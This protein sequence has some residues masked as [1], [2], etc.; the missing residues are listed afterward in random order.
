[1]PSVRVNRE[2]FLGVL[3]SVEPGLAKKETLEQ[4]NSFIFRK[5]R[6]LT[7]NDEIACRAPSGLS[8]EFTGAVAAKP[9]LALLDKLK[10]ETIHVEPDGGELIITG[11][12]GRSSGIL[13]DA[14]I[15]LDVDA[16]EEPGEWRQLPEGF[17]E[18]VSLVATCA[19]GDASY[20][21]RVCI[22]L[23]PKWIE[24]CDNYQITRYRI[25]TG[26]TENYLLRQ[27]SLSQ[28][29]A[30]GVTE[31]SESAAWAHF[32]FPASGLT[33]SCRRYL[34]EFP[35][36]SKLLE[37]GNAQ[38]TVLPKALAEAAERAEIFSAENADDNKLHIEMSPGKL[39][40]KGEGTKGWYRE[41]QQ[42]TYQG[43]PI[44]FLISPKMLKEIL[45]RHNEVLISAERL[46][47]ESDRW[48]YVSCL[49]KPE[50]PKPKQQAAE[51]EP[52]ASTEE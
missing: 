40:I 44:R 37:V 22:Y 51:E 2:S 27:E 18:A 16:I 41:R 31:I 43:P 39:R 49:G 48:Q 42:V 50:E 35:D 30:L 29:T 47:V 21:Y 15:H 20:L 45:Q 11:E 36:L 6:V 10:E 23:T 33:V 5:G 38:P 1:M 14:E 3:R 17:A 25:R 26:V 32:R 12:K 34:E 24:A 7:F 19:K 52:V 9:L 46:K 13:M 4:S 28:V 8:K